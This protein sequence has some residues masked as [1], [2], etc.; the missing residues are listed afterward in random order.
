[1]IQ[2][3]SPATL[4]AATAND[5]P[6]I[7]RLLLDAGLPLDGVSDAVSDF[8]VA[9]DGDDLV[10]G[11]GVE[12]RGEDARLRSVAVAASWRSRGVGRAIV[13]HLFAEAEAR[14]LRAL[15]LLTTTAERWFPSFGFEHITRAEVP[16]GVRETSEFAT[17]CPASATVMRCRL[18][19]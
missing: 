6:A 2:E 3:H 4:R 15:Y 17:A 16:S 19:R 11:G 14:G 9:S 5:L 7:T 18:A 12:V 1:M 8:V 10:G 13:M